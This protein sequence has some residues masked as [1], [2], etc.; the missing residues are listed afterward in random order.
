MALLFTCLGAFAIAVY[1]IEAGQKIR[2]LDQNPG[3]EFKGFISQKFSNQFVNAM[4]SQYLLGL[5]SFETDDYFSN[6]QSDLLWVYFIFGTL[7]TQ[8]VFM[9]TLIA[10]LGDTYGNVTEKKQFNAM[11]STINVVN[12]ILFLVKDKW[13]IKNSY[14]YVAKKKDLGEEGE[15]WAGAV[16]SIKKKLTRNHNQ[17]LQVQ[18]AQAQE[19]HLLRE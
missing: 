16:A 3:E 6:E 19:L 8:I 7:L 14:F 4:L 17:V 2:F 1:L 18:E 10:I 15:E 11:L 5:G 9:N 13:I 12:D